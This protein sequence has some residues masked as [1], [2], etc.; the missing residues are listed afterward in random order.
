MDADKRAA[1]R[2]RRIVFAAH[3]VLFVLVRMVVGSLPQM[4]PSGTYE[5]IFV[6]GV[7]LFAHW[8]ALAYR[9]ARDGVA[10]P[11]HWLNRLVVPRERRWLLLVI[12]AMLWFIAQAGVTGLIIPHYYYARYENLVWAVWSVQTLV[13][14]AHLGLAAYAEM[15]DRIALRKRKNDD[16][17]QAALPADDGELIDFPA[18]EGAQPKQQIQ[19]E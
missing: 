19:R 12:D 5:A 11:F 2:R 15:D 7:F 17:A 4:P 18:V 8:L 9:E 1:I 13:L 10:L 6:W 14:L 3:G 16:K